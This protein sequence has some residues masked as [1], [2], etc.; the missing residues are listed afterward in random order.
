LNTGVLDQK[1]RLRLRN[2]NGTQI[3]MARRPE[4]GMHHVWE[5]NLQAAGLPPHFG[6]IFFTTSHGW[7]MGWFMMG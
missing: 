7:L 6:M 3:T 1:T 5:G 4:L 2:V